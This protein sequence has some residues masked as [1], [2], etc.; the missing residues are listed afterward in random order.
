MTAY[1]SV[2]NPDRYLDEDGNCDYFIP[3]MEGFDEKND[4]AK[5]E[6]QNSKRMEANR[7]ILRSRLG[8]DFDGR[9]AS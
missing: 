3:V 6:N 7:E 2:F 8:K 1:S 4:K 9:G 5:K